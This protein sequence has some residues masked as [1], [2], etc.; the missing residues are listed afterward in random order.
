MRVLHVHDCWPVTGDLV[1][2]LKMLGVEAEIFEPTIGTYQ[3]SKLRRA[4]LPIIRTWESYRLR[5]LIHYKQFDIVHVH[6]ARHA[7]MTLLTGIPYFLHC[8]GSDLRLDLRRP[9]LRE[10]VKLAIRKAQKVFYVTPDLSK[11]FTDIRDDSVFL[12]NPVN[13][14]QF[15]FVPGEKEPLPRILCISK[16]DQ[17]KGVEHTLRTIE[18]VWYTRPQTEV[19]V[20]NF[21]NSD[22]AKSFIEEHRQD[23]RLI[24]LPRT[25]HTE[26][27]AL[28]RSFTVVLGQQ[29][30]EVGALGVSELEAMA[31]GKP[32]VCYYDYPEAYPEPPPIL[33]SRSPE[34]ASAQ[35]IRL[36]DDA[37]L[38][39]NLGVA[40]RAWVSKYHEMGQVAQVLLDHYQRY[41]GWNF[42]D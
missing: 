21:G 25:Q 2:G 10:L 20:F 14:A 8:H 3:A 24:L 13:L 19:A 17:F 22:E 39:Q 34:E 4:A 16:L 26:M 15:V 37:N 32:V 18:L 35:I 5:K 33:V 1:R 38:R 7:Y 23:S 41:L 6:Y 12:P 40:A 9:G 11:Y 36:L 28:I 27:P 29:S 31:C 30:Q 42:N